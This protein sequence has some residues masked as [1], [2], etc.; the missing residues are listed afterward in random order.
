MEITIAQFWRVAANLQLSLNFDVNLRKEFGKVL[1]LSAKEPKAGRSSQKGLL[2]ESLQ[3]N[4]MNQFRV[5]D[6]FI[7]S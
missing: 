5:L 3:V 4:S 7:G 6:K 1:N 2:G